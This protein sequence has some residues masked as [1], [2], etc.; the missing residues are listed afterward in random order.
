MDPLEMS[1]IIESYPLEDCTAVL[2][3]SAPH[4]LEFIEQDLILRR[5][6]PQT[7]KKARRLIYDALA[8]ERMR[9]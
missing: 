9:N 8:Q 6:D 5:D 1:M 4:M 3:I 7:L 2:A